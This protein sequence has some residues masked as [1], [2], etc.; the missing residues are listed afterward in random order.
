VSNFDKKIKV[1][2]FVGLGGI[3][4]V[5][6]NFLE[7]CKFLKKNNLLSN[8]RI[9]T[10]GK[11]DV[12]YQA[13]MQLK[14]FNILNLI[15]FFKLIKDIVSSKVIFH[16][17]N[18]LSSKKFRLLVFFLKPKK[19]I[20]HERG[21]IWNQNLS[22]KKSIKNTALKASFIIA[23]SNATKN[24]LNLKFGIP[25]KKIQVIHNGIGIENDQTTKQTSQD[26][27]NVG[28]LGRIEFHKGLHIL[29][30]A[31]EILKDKNV[32]FLIGGDGP[33]RI[34]LEKKFSHCKKIKF[35]GR[36]EDVKN[37]F[38]RVD[39]LVVPSIREPFGNVIIEAGK[40]NT[41]V[42][43]TFI[44]GI[45]EILNKTNAGILI[46]P[47]VLIEKTESY[48]NFPDTVINPE[49]NSLEAPRQIS[50]K[51]LA[52]KISFFLENPKKLSS[53]G[54]NL[55]SIVEKEFSIEEYSKKFYRLYQ[56]V[57]NEI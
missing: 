57:F 12:E 5:Q 52:K 56:I 41:A 15:N 32:S 30:E 3:G 38:S 4:G 13:K 24:L 25:K 2:H 36:V 16:S 53:C 19:F 29:L 33:L 10:L 23:N 11:V 6:S 45:P 48:E 34:K 50:K 40:Y 39:L 26:N 54:N 37:F 35:L 7:F 18:N 44:D 22:S 28:F 9:Y 46:K 49:T 42:I 8:H 31:A 27:I 20:I 51:E 55:R 21:T 1:S 14:V 17:Y 47:R 43:A